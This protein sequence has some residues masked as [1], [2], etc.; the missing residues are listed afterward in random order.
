MDK[1]K[2]LEMYQKN[3]NNY[4]VIEGS[5][6]NCKQVA[7]GVDLVSLYQ[8]KFRYYEKRNYDKIRKEYNMRVI[9]F[10]IYKTKS[11]K[12]PFMWN[13][14]ASNGRMYCSSER[15]TQKASAKAS[16][17]NIIKA[18]QAGSFTVEDIK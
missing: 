18:I 6:P 9:H 16:I 17:K 13:L 4:I 3:P 14:T 7:A 12:E 2:I 10:E 1:L 5:Y 15:F 11:K 8:N